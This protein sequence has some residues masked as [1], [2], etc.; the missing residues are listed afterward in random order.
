MRWLQNPPSETIRL[1]ALAVEA[2]RN[3]GIDPTASV[4]VLRGYSV[5]LVM[6]APDGFGSADLAAVRSFAEE[7]RFDLVAAP[8]LTAAEANRF[9]VVPGDPY[10]PAST[11]LLAAAD[12]A[13]IYRAAEYDIRPPTD[14]HPFFGHFFR[15]SQASEVLESLGT[16][17]QPFG[18]AGYL[19]LVALLILAASGA[20]LLI[21]LP[22]VLG[23]R[24]RTR[25]AGGRLWTLAYFGL[26]G[27]GFLFVEIPLIQ[28]YILLIGHPTS[29]LAVV[30]FALLLSSGIGS[31]LSDRVP[32]RPGAAALTAMI[33]AMVPAVAVTSDL[34]LAAP[35]WIRMPV[36][37]LLLAP[38]GFLMGIMFPKG[39]AHLEDAVP[40][41][42]PWAWGVNG[43]FSVISAVAAALL[44]LTSGFR[45]VIALGAVCYG[46]CIPLAGAS[47]TRRG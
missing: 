45:S 39:I 42:V 23:R 6:V 10:H 15:W 5:G 2:A 41:L 21:I 14:D 43:T 40:D 3:D 31:A 46:L 24:R 11:A 1:V 19:V 25:S 47:L 16:T 12:P 27:I 29:A 28:R 30:L 4:L 8:G 13:A 26:L 34:L 32:W 37:A 33:L 44:A 7:R 22:L 17:W 18:G 35:L 9:N 20:A 38:L 36:G